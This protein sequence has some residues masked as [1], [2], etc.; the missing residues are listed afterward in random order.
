MAGVVV[1]ISGPGEA[2]VG[3]VVPFFARDF[4]GFAADANARIGEE[5]DFDMI[6]HVGVPALIRALNAFADHRLSTLVSSSMLP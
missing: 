6:L 2:V 1:G 5:S 3:H 4:A